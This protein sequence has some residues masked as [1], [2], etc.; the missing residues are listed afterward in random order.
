M[1]VGQQDAN[2][3]QAQQCSSSIYTYYK[4]LNFDYTST[5]IKQL[6]T[7][8]YSTVEIRAKTAA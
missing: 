2:H 1:A 3:M 8:S 5:L 4:A 7:Q 6:S